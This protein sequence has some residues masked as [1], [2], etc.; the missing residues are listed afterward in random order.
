[1]TKTT[2]SGD[3]D[4]QIVTI[5]AHL[6][7]DA[8]VTDRL[9]D[10][11]QATAALKDSLF[12]HGQQ[13]PVLVRPNAARPGRFEIVYGRRR[14]AAL[15]DLGLPV[16]AM[17]RVMDDT[18]L[19]V[20]QG[21]ENSARQDLSF[22][23]RASFATRLSEAGHDRA[24]IAAALSCDLPNVSRLIRTGSDLP[25]EF[26]R[27][28]GAAPGIGR[29]RWMAL[30][31]LFRSDPPARRRAYD[32]T[33]R[34]GFA[35]CATDARFETV[36]AAATALPQGPTRSTSPKPLTLRGA[37][38]TALADLRRTRRGVTLTLP[39][40]E[41]G[42][43]AWVADHAG[44]LLAEWYNRWQ[45]AHAITEHEGETPGDLPPGNPQRHVET[46][47]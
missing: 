8:G 13:V 40:R 28:I 32:A 44:D 34:A 29:G 19:V 9:S 7:D 45:R 43:G 27:R 1:M 2:P 22:I 6:I 41:D 21:Q 39:A 47:A 15:R 17:V 11:P 24:T 3:T 42:F 25:L 38:G 18:A 33:R 37:D 23:E 4:S 20:A 26:L 16:R 10:D 5:A 12:N 14:L 35:A 30:V 31:R 46:K 36:F